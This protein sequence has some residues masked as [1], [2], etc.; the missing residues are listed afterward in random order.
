M[1]DLNATFEPASA[2]AELLKKARRDNTIAMIL[3]GAGGG[4]VGFS[5]GTALGGG[6]PNWAM[7]G[8]GA[9]LIIVAIPISN[10]AGN[11]TREAVELYNTS[12]NSKK[13]IVS[14]PQ[15]F[16][17]TSATGIGFSLVF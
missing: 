10:S 11:K 1:G 8:I 2:S 13:A 7:A 5:L 16:L 17:T 15:F 4:L 9:G 6:D 14:R 12:I 3:G